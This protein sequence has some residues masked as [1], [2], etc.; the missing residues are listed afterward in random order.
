M[1]ST[2]QRSG[3]K[4]GPST[5]GSDDDDDDGEPPPRTKKLLPSPRRLPTR[6]L[7][8]QQPSPSIRVVIMC[9]AGTGTRS[10]GCSPSLAAATD[11]DDGVVDDDATSFF[12]TLRFFLARR[13]AVFNGAWRGSMTSRIR[14]CLVLPIAYW[15]GWLHGRTGPCM[16]SI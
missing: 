10:G 8:R 14:G 3:S 15:P 4:R 9:V 11:T 2:S 1:S 12:I 13:G 5:S 6:R 7:P 16:R